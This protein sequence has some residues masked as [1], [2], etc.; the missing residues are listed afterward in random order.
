MQSTKIDN[1]YIITTIFN[2]HRLYNVVRDLRVHFPDCDIQVCIWVNKNNVV[3]DDTWYAKSDKEHFGTITEVQINDWCWC[4]ENRNIWCAMSHMNIV[5]DALDKWYNNIIVCEDDLLLWTRTRQ[6][7]NMYMEH[8]PD[9][10]ELLRLSRK[11]YD[12]SS[13]KEVNSCFFKWNAW[14][15][16]MYM[17]NKEW[18]KKFY[19]SFRD[20]FYWSTDAQMWK[21]HN[22]NI[23]IAKCPLGIQRNNYDIDNS[24]TFGNKNYSIKDSSSGWY[25]IAKKKKYLNITTI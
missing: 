15:C 4:W 7:F 20:D 11:P 5:K 2:W 13:L 8:L 16:E 14:G 9:N 18:I 22:I 3:I 6:N 1:I 25:I 12:L 19:E 23:F 17:L 10:W 24:D 21:W